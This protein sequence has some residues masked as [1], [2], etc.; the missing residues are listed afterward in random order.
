MKGARIMREQAIR[1]LDHLFEKVF[2]SDKG[3]REAYEEW[4][5][6]EGLCEE[7]AGEEDITDQMRPPGTLEFLLALG[8]TPQ[9]I[10][11]VI[12]LN[13]EIFDQQICDAYGMTPPKKD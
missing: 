3:S 2:G 11:D 5:T 6:N 10:V 9:E 1:S 12:H 4:A 8:V 13:P 7:W